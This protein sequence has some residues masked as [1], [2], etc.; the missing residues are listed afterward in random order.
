MSTMD[1][2]A[3]HERIEDLLLEPTRLD[4]LA[5]SGAPG[6]IALREHLAGCPSCRA[7]LDGWH[8]LQRGL[9]ASL[10]SP[11]G[12]AAAVAPIEVPP[13]MRTR[14]LA[15][16]RSSHRAVVPLPIER[17]AHARQRGAWFGLLAASLVVVLGATAVTLDQAG[18]RTVAEAESDAL[19]TIVVAVDKVLAAPHRIVE[20]QRPDGTAAG[21]ISWSRHDWIVLTTAIAEPPGDQRFMCWLEEDGRSVPVGVMDFAGGTAYWVAS[22]DDWATWEI[23]P[24]TRFVVTLE[25]IGTQARSGPTVL[26]ADL[27]A[28]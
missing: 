12:A 2:A 11:A 5:G 4:A 23:G 1:H 16:I 28:S 13:S 25:A 19:A 8:R 3:A 27:G 7:D 9:A 14:V 20:L 26:S 18:R 6:D 15:A 24:E 22:L 21:S 10:P 17:P